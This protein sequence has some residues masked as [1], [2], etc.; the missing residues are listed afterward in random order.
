M[1]TLRTLVLFSLL[2][3]L[4]ILSGCTNM[5][6]VPL[7]SR[8]TFNFNV[9]SLGERKN[10]TAVMFPF[11]DGREM[12]YRLSRWEEFPALGLFFMFIPSKHTYPEVTFNHYQMAISDIKGDQAE[13]LKGDFASSV[14]RKFGE[15][16][17]AAGVFKEVKFAEDLDENF[18]MRDYDY[19]IRGRL[20]KSELR[21]RNFTYG[22]NFFGLMDF[23]WVLKLLAAPD[24]SVVAE[25]AYEVEI[26]ERQTGRS[27]W[28]GKIEYEPRS[29]IVGYYYGH[30]VEG[31]A[32]NLGLFVRILE[33]DMSASINKVKSEIKY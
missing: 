30:R 7:D 3:S 8:L 28:K 32:P 20:L 29:Q 2:G 25:V 10:Y 12:E 26:V 18:D 21:L 9:D 27:V 15:G 5:K 1:K 22:L 24:K 11:S 4:L 16:L 33:K 6:V 17:K 31:C 23:S 13:Y 14:P 19:I